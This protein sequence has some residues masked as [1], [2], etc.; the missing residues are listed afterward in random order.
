MVD[1]I[2]A[3]GRVGKVWQWGSLLDRG[4]FS[5]ISDIDVAVEGL[6][7]PEAYFELLGTLAELTDFPVDLVELEK[8]HEADARAIRERGRLVHERNG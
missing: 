1:A 2:K 5:E 3:D 4:R 8:A 6:P 7:G